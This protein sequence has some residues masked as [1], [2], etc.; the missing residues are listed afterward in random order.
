MNTKIPPGTRL[1]PD[2]LLPA[3]GEEY[4]HRMT[5]EIVRLTSWMPAVN[6]AIVERDSGKRMTCTVEG[7]WKFYIHVKARP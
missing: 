4:R 6:I 3:V 1:T 2:D 7:F 5:G